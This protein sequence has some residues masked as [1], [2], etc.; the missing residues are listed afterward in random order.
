MEFCLELGCRS[1]RLDFLAALNIVHNSGKETFIDFSGP[2]V[3]RWTVSPGG[4]NVQNSAVG[5]LS[6][7][8]GFTETRQTLGPKLGHY[9][10]PRN[11]WLMEDRD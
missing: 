6:M 8:G 4:H 1:L 7:P 9:Q 2:Y 10:G 11:V 3:Y 5:C